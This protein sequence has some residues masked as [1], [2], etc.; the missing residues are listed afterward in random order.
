MSV[1]GIIFLS[2]LSSLGVGLTILEYYHIFRAKRIEFVCLCFGENREDFKPD[3]LVI[4]RT[5]AEQEE[6]IRRI[7][8]N[9]PRKV[10]IKY[11]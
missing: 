5:D 7:S 4:C 6:I 2:L 10:F 1:L 8:A 11:I 9:E 3:M